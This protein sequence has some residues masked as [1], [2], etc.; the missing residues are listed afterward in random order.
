[1]DGI[2]LPRTVEGHMKIDDVVCGASSVLLQ[3]TSCLV[4]AGICES[5]EDCSL[6]GCKCGHAAV[7]HVAPSSP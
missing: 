3:I 5:V 2:Y 4:T 1:M 6:E 7:G